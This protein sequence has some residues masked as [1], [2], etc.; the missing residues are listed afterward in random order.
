MC[1]GHF[2]LSHCQ[3]SEESWPLGDYHQVEACD[4]QIALLHCKFY[5]A[6]CELWLPACPVPLSETYTSSYDFCCCFMVGMGKGGRVSSALMSA[7]KVFCATCPNNLTF[8]QI[9]IHMYLGDCH[10][11]YMEGNINLLVSY[12]SKKTPHCWQVLWWFQQCLLQD[13]TTMLILNTVQAKSWN[14]AD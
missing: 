12:H 4:V 8:W 6:C 7:S 14:L 2:C 10:Q 9:H 1:N 13:T 11:R 3:C 5:P